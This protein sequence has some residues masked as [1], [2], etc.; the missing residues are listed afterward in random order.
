MSDSPDA[1]TDAPIVIDHYTDVLCVWA[2]VGHARVVELAM[3]F[4]PRIHIRTHFCSV[5]PDTQ[6][7]FGVGWKKRGGYEG[8]ARHVAHVCADFPHVALHET[9]WRDVR[10]PSS[11]PIHMFLKAVELLE[12]ADTGMKSEDIPYLERISTRAAWALRHGFFAEGRDMADFN[13]QNDVARDLGLDPERICTPEV[14][15]RAVAA[16]AKDFDL[17]RSQNVEGS[18]TF[19]LNQGRQKL[20]GNVGYRLLEANVEEL[21][22]RPAVDAVSWC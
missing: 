1:Q 6:E 2:Y 4:G 3:K 15:A 19:V 18:P 17:T 21:L 11:A 16:L 9:A 22:R 7:K 12:E 20:F 13:V 8:Y 5:F 14:Q 10:P